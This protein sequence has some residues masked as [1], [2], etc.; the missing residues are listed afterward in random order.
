[1]DNI[2][3]ALIFNINTVFNWPKGFARLV[4]SFFVDER[5]WVSRAGMGDF[6][7]SSC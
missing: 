6:L 7:R 4:L 1:M 2:L 5:N 3:R